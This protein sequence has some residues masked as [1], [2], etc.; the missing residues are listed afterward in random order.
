MISK[1]IAILKVEIHSKR[2]LIEA[3]TS[4]NRYNR[5][6]LEILLKYFHKMHTEQTDKSPYTGTSYKQQQ[7]NN[8][9]RGKVKNSVMDT[10][11]SG[12]LNS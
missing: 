1:I 12:S 7:Q 5:N 10:E 11:K 9:F 6:T 2:S 8:K 3:S 4:C